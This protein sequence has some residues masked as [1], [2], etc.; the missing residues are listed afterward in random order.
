MILDSL[1]ERCSNPEEVANKLGG[2]CENAIARKRIDGLS[3]DNQRLL[4]K[5]LDISDF[6]Y[7]FLNYNPESIAL[8]GT[9]PEFPD[10]DSGLMEPVALRRF[11]YRTLLAISSLDLANTRP[12]D[13]VLAL[14]TRLADC[15]IAD[16]NKRSANRAGTTTEHDPHQDVA[17]FALGKLG[18]EEINYSSDIDL[19]FVAAENSAD[20]MEDQIRHVREF[21]RLM[22]TRTDEGF[23]YRV[24]LNL[25]PW[26]RSAP[27]I[28][29]VDATE[30]YYEARGDVW[31]RFAWLRARPIAG[32]Y[33]LANDLLARLDPFVFHKA[34]GA[35]DLERFIQMKSAMAELRHRRGI[36]NIKTGEGGIRDIEFFVQLLQI[37]NGGRIEALKVTSTIRA[38]AQLHRHGLLTRAECLQLKE[39]Y[40]F[41][42]KLEHRVQMQDE[43]QTHAL[44]EEKNKLLR[45]ACSMG[46]PDG[47]PE[48]QYA[49]FNEDLAIHRQVARQF[50]DRVL[51]DQIDME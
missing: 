22:E 8:I 3:G 4:I 36:W 49:D 48:R 41:L 40:F 26:G 42:R 6:L 7:R 39:S 45:I 31:E 38:L 16:V 29:D 20:R 2:L 43:Q 27:L 9:E 35:D 34:L 1:I 14:L 17:V 12:Y 18:A 33:Q 25:R 10:A 13:D 46:Y 47:C 24:D 44:P 23:L 5:I 51:N 50:F 37:A 28:L 32:N 19:I 21:C 30:Q 15:I 11:K